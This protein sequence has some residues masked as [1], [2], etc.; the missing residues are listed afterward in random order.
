[1]IN[2]SWKAKEIPAMEELIRYLNQ[3]SKAELI[4]EIIDLYN[5]FDSLKD[6]FS[7]RYDSRQNATLIL[8]YKELLKGV[9]FSD[10]Y[11]GSSSL[12]RAKGIV[13]LFSK[14][15]TMEEHTVD[16]MIYLVELGVEFTNEYGDIDE[17]FYSS[18]EKM[19]AKAL[20]YISRNALLEK[21]KSRC[22]KIVVDTKGIG[23]GFHDTLA[24]AYYDTYKDDS[25]LSEPLL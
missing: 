24:D 6:Y 18:M 19:F 2:K 13:T 22:R 16:I 20:D 17:A 23:W 12:S 9:F 25:L 10:D 8:K 1:V 5:N 3:K 4:S 21:F 15:S 7:A 11:K 14:I